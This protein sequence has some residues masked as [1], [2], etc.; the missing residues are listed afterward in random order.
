MEYNPRNRDH[1]PGGC[2]C[3]ITLK[4]ITKGLQKKKISYKLLKIGNYVNKMAVIFEREINDF[5]CIDISNAQELV[6]RVSEV[7]VRDIQS[8]EIDVIIPNK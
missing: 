6:D 1:Y 8:Q 5:E 7:I 4:D 3:G 2:P